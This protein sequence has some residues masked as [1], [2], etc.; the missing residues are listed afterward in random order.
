M[1]TYISMDITIEM[2]AAAI[3]KGRDDKRKVVGQDSFTSPN[4]CR[5][6]VQ[7]TVAG[8][9][10]IDVMTPVAWLSV[11]QVCSSPNTMSFTS[12]FK[13]HTSFQI[14]FLQVCT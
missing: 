5:L 13:D 14:T 10:N 9:S 11:T 4:G 8:Q 7:S 3:G 2:I 1:Q 12:P 6:C